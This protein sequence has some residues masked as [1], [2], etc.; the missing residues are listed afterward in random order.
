MHI[1]TYH[2]HT[3]THFK[4][5]INQAHSKISMYS[6][7]EKSCT[8][9]HTTSQILDTCTHFKPTNHT[10]LHTFQVHGLELTTFFHGHLH[11]AKEKDTEKINPYHHPYVRKNRISLHNTT[12]SRSDCKFMQHV[13]TGT[14][15]L[16]FT[17]DH[18]AWTELST[19]L[20]TT[21]VTW[22]PHMHTNTDGKERDVV[23]T[24]PQL[25]SAG[26][27]PWR[28][29]PPQQSLLSPW[30]SE[31]RFDPP[32]HLDSVPLHVKKEWHRQGHI[33]ARGLCIQRGHTKHTKH[34]HTQEREYGRYRAHPRRLV[35]EQRVQEEVE[36][37]AGV[38]EEAAVLPP[39]CC[40]HRQEGEQDK[41]NRESQKQWRRGVENKGEEGQKIH[42]HR[43]LL[44]ARRVSSGE[45]GIHEE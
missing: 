43:K 28:Q 38:L 13:A 32:Q 44:F 22:S 33:S 23:E 41:G 10:G 18:A 19:S 37:E 45:D 5:K 4:P 26:R 35:Q 29:H 17:K 34:T 11:L 21:A 9:A 31:L 14:H 16:R 3:H 25:Q 7:V 30:Q 6:L 8:C 1:F 36:V 39:R 42:H 27:A 24:G 20:L 2:R 40:V 15:T 12:A